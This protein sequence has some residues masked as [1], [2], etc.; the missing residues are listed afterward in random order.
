MESVFQWKFR[1]NNIFRAL[2]SSLYAMMS[3]PIRYNSL[4]IF[5]CQ[6]KYVFNRIAI[7]MYFGIILISLTLVTVYQDPIQIFKPI[8]YAIT[9]NN[10]TI[11][12]NDFCGSGVPFEKDCN[13]MSISIEMLLIWMYINWGLYSLSFSYA[14]FAPYLPCGI[15][16]MFKG[17][18]ITNC[19]SGLSRFSN[20]DLELF[21]SI[22]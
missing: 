13:Q 11:N 6:W 3:C 9:L 17:R 18:C 4:D 1:S 12:C 7:K 2:E 8:T 10:S 21:D 20:P 16:N 22:S 14:V 15:K 19:P 5:D